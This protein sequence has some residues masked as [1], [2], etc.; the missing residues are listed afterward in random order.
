MSHPVARF[1]IEFALAIVSAF[2]FVL[3]LLTREWIEIVFGVEPDGGSGVL[4]WAITL[5]FLLAAV[6]LFVLARHDQRRAL[7]AST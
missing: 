7:A 4:E 3:T 6:S 1:R 5:A 2:L